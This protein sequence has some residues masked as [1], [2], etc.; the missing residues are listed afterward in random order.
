MQA[1]DRC[2]ATEDVAV[3][4]GW[5]F[6]SPG[7]GR[8]SSAR[9]VLRALGCDDATPPRGVAPHAP[10]RS[11]PPQGGSPLLG[12]P[13]SGA[14]ASARRQSPVRLRGL[15]AGGPAGGVVRRV[16]SRYFAA[17]ARS[18]HGTSQR[19]ARDGC[20][21]PS[22][23]RALGSLPLSLSPAAPSPPRQAAVAWRPPRSP[24]GLLEELFWDRPWAL[25]LCCILL[26]QTTRRQV[27]PVLANLFAAYP[28]ALALAAAE[29]ET[30]E[31]LL[32]PLGL[33]RQRSRSI[34]AFSRAFAAG[35]WVRPEEL[36]GV[37]KYG[38][39]AHA[40]FC[41]GRYRE[42]EPKDHAL[43]WYCAWLVGLDNRSE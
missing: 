15:P 32:R 33:H 22:S 18:G 37:G 23:E 26:N 25:L 30:L 3:R 14:S 9:A 10:S 16:A 38:G 5:V 29:P 8:F 19:G 24:F 34:V 40:I 43:N 35:G 11:A 12:A 39:D 6:V 42:T 2:G 21:S 28:D 41:L 4:E 20:H 7:G 13:S 27:D 17:D 36:P 1:V 31:P